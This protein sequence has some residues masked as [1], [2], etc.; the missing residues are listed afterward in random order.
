MSVTAIKKEIEDS[1]EEFVVFSGLH[2]MESD[3]VQLLAEM[4]KRKR[5]DYERC[6][7]CGDIYC[8]YNY[9]QM[10]DCPSCNSADLQEEQEA[11]DKSPNCQKISNQELMPMIRYKA[12]LKKAKKEPYAKFLSLA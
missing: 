8:T 1:A 3:D 10:G 5:T 11:W 12:I 7:N 4:L 2:V 6:C 9:T